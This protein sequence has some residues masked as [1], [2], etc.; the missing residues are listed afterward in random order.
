MKIKE[1]IKQN[2]KLIL[3]VLVAG[4]ILGWLVSP[5]S[6]GSR[7]R[8][9]SVPAAD[10]H[11]HIESAEAEQIWTCSMHPQIKQNHPGNCPICG[12]E[13]IPLTQETA[14]NRETDPNEIQMTEDAMKLAEIQTVIVRRGKPDKDVILQGKIKA[15]ER[16]IAKLTARFGGRIEKLFVNFTGQRVR[17]GEKLGVIYSPDLITAQ[18]E[19]LEAT[20][21]KDSNPSF[22][23]ASRSKLKLWDLTEEQID[24]IESSGDPVVYF[25]ILSP[26][27]GTVTK[28]NVTTGDYVKEGSP[29]FEVTDLSRVW[30]LFDA[31]E[32]DLP[33]I[34]LGDEIEFTVEAIPAEKFKGKVS[35][36]DPLL[37]PKTRVARG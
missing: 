34:S 2:Y 1:T 9:T 3:I 16:N 19:L 5:S 12:M 14:S 10:A 32:T 31:Y 4:I 8:Q 35:F 37:D 24:A 15:D 6:G 27:S 25:D 29:L 28:R 26:I 11:E 36:I 7:N 20:K 33:W 21:Y 22:Y 13:L 18:R 23:K 17:K 30:V